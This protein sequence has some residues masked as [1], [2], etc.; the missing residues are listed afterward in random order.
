MENIFWIILSIDWLIDWSHTTKTLP[1]LGF[2]P[3]TWKRGTRTATAYC[4]TQ[5]SN[6]CS[7]GSLLFLRQ[8]NHVQGCTCF[9]PERLTN[10]VQK[11]K[12]SPK[13]HDFISNLNLKTVFFLLRSYNVCDPVFHGARGIAA[14]QNRYRTH[15]LTLRRR[16]HAQWAFFIL[17]IYSHRL[18]LLG[19]KGLSN[20]AC[21]DI[22][23]YDFCFGN[24]MEVRFCTQGSYLP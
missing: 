24:R 23:L 15:R 16:L 21:H 1:W 22:I 7:L 17:F 5:S 14:V 8:D 11:Q 18:S 19:T 10:L 6:G 9:R 2:E 4:S 12:S 13:I 3:Q 20:T